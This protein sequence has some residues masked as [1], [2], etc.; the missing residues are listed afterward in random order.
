MG[1]RIDVAAIPKP[2]DVGPEMEAL[3]RFFRPCTWEGT[4][5]EGGMGP[6]TPAMRGVGR[7]VVEPIQGGRWIAGDFEQD[8]FLEDGSF[9]LRWQ[10]H[11]SRGGTPSTASNRASMVDNYG[12]ADVYRGHI[13]GDRL[14]FESMPGSEHSV[15][16]G[17]RR[18]PPSPGGGTS[19]R[20][21]AAPGSSSRST[22]WCR[23]E[24]QGIENAGAGIAIAHLKS[25]ASVVPAA[26]NAATMPGRHPMWPTVWP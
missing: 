3:E 10:L 1:T 23:P 13:D 24:G 26:K 17:M 9:V 12:H 20:S 15:S 11:W 2:I 19:W 4:I 25:R 21:R 6:G 8:Q 14:V 5:H 7:G 22:R 18:I 16:H